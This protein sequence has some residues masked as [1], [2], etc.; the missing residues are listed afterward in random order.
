MDNHILGVSV[1]DQSLTPASAELRIVVQVAHR[2]PRTEVRGRLMGPSCPFAS[3]VEVAYPLRP[4]PAADELAA[5]VVIP[6]PSLWD[7]QSPFLY[8]G[9]VELWEDGHRREVVQVRHGLRVFR[10]GPKGLTVNGR[11]LALRGKELTTACPDDEAL[12][13]R[14]AGYNLLVASVTDETAPLWDTGDRLGFVV[15]GRVADADADTAA[16]LDRLRRHPSC[17]GWLAADGSPAPEGSLP[18]GAAEFFGPI[19]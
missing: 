16:R 18:P 13:L 15:A 19:D 10:L 4:L 14:R 6:E 2:T 9:P 1:R 3:T 7:P 12:R 8:G 17:L 11:P 5:R